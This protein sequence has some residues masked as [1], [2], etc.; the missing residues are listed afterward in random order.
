MAALTCSFA[1]ALSAAQAPAACPVSAERIEGE[2]TRVTPG[3]QYRAGWPRRFLLGSEYR[4]LWTTP[5]AVPVLDLERFASGLEPAKKGGGKQTLSLEFKGGDGREYKFRSVDKDP[6]AVLPRVLQGTFADRVVEDQISSAHP[7]GELVV[8]PLLQAAGLLHVEPRLVV[9]PDHPLLREFRAEFGGMLGTFAEVPRADDPVTP[10]FEGVSKILSSEKLMKLIEEGPGDRIDAR[11]FL[12]ARLVD[13]FL[14]DWDRHQKQWSWAKTKD[15]QLYEPVPK[16][17]DQAFVK[18]D[19]FLLALTRLSDPRLVDFGED[20]PGMRGMMWNSRDLDRRLLSGLE[21]PE[22]DEVVA[23]LQE[24]LSDDVIDMAVCRLP[25]EYRTMEAPRL[26][27]VLKARR[28]R[29]PRAALEFYRLLA[30]EI[31]VF[32]TNADDVALIARH[33]KGEVELRL[34]ATGEEGQGLSAPYFRRRFRPQETREVRVYLLGG[35][36]QVVSRGDAERR[37]TMRVIGG[38]GNDTLDDS[39]G[40]GTRFYDEQSPRLVL[41]GPGTSKDDRPYE[42]PGGPE[43]GRPLDWGR[44]VVPL[45]YLRADP[46]I[47]FLLGGGAQLT[48]Y[49]FRKHPYDSRHTAR[50]AYST[51]AQSYRA[52]Y[53]GDFR[54]ANSKARGLLRLRASGLEVLRFYGFG[55]DGPAPGAD[56]LYRVEQ[57]QYAIAPSFEFE[58]SRASVSFGPIAKFATTRLPPGQFISLARPYGTDDFGQLGAGMTMELDLRDRPGVAR[59]G[60]LLTTGASVFPAVWSVKSTFGEVRAEAA[61][62]L[63]LPLPQ[64]PTVAVRVG[65]KRVF[66]VYPFQEAAFLGGPLTLRGLE[67]NR[68]AGDASLYANAELRVPLGRLPFL[69]AGEAGLFALWDVGRVYLE[70]ESSNRWH[71]GVGGGFW[72]AF[73]GGARTVSV[74][75]AHSEKRTGV[76]LQGGLLF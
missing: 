35:N 74:A 25:P 47:G 72:M 34:S 1:R 53:E 59:R 16:D 24:E 70:G 64:D 48:R 9:L 30:R 66:G 42:A 26:A 52:E 4:N 14:G 51:G 37:I 46:E 19:G 17:R 23:E 32:A 21:R 68:Y 22:W 61:T 62:Y 15:H 60:F 36:D 40:G 57:Q 29:L 8:S 11:A 13:I 44:S 5:I 3:P 76:Y 28:A 75:V 50:V 45:P 67:R 7:A 33:E 27:A 55:N 56:D 58:R 73:Q 20:Y 71:T 69:F 10:G 38:Q 41:V 12:K 39:N 6:S 2:M 54:R 65:G 43:D 31:D 49:G 63:P 18:F